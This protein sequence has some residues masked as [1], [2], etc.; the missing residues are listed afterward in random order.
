MDIA[1]IFMNGRSQAVRLPKAYRFDDEEVF[2]ARIDD[3][4]VLYPRKRGWDLLAR[5]IERFTADFMEERD[6]PGGV[7]QR[8]DL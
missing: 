5:G 2:I 1:R 8:S 6:Q 3:M 7:D 4:V